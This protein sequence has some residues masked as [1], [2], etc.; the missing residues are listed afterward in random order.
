ML[1]ILVLMPCTSLLAAD[2]ITVTSFGGAFSQSQ[3]EAYQKPFMKKT[4]IKVNAEVYNGG[5]AEIRAQ[6]QSGNVTWDVADVEKQD[7]TAGCDEGLF[8]QIDPAMLAPAPDGTP[9]TKDFLPGAIHECGVATIVWTTIVAYDKTKFPGEKPSKLA[10]FFDVKKFPGMRGISKRT[11][12]A[13]EFALMAEGVPPADVYKVLSTP[14]GLDRAFKKFDAIKANLI[15]WEAGAQP[16]QMLA[17]GEVVMT[18]AYNGRIF[19][20]QVKENKPFEIIW[21]HQVYNM[22]YYAILKGTKHKKTALEF[23]KY[24]TSTQ[25]LADQASWISYGPSRKS[26]V[27][28]IKTYT[29]TDIQMGPHMPTAPQN[30][31]NA[32]ASD[33]EWWADHQDEVLKRYS[34]WMA[35]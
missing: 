7:L 31:K 30:I 11:V 34:A 3:I 29:G 19:N 18:T 24:A 16:P 9:A 14:A 17:D 27:P 2:S 32:L 15:F 8:E 21:D 10:D 26:S 28:L 4:G 6:V 25:A 22:D 12:V 35:K 23:L 1:S 20:A 13:M 5:L 33:D